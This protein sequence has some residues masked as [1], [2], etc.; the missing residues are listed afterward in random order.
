MA[1]EA[2]RSCPFCGAGALTII[3]KVD[4]DYTVRVEC[5]ECH[6]STP[7][8]IYRPSRI[9][10]TQLYHMGWVPTLETAREEAVKIWN[11]RVGD[12]QIRR[13]RQLLE[14]FVPEDPA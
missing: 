8:V 1:I 10:N 2:L 13:R 6:A 11:E 14:D 3:S 9:D 12:P 4:G 5:I 7:S